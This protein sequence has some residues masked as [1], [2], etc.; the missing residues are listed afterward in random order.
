MAALTDQQWSVEWMEGSSSRIAVI[1][2]KNVTAADTVDLS[3][4]FSRLK[5]A[6][7]CGTTVIGTGTGG[8]SGTVLT[9]PAGLSNDG[10]VALV[11]GAAL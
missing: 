2:L 8:V 4:V 10:A 5:N 3:R 6:V 1:A 7:V 9:L 11:F